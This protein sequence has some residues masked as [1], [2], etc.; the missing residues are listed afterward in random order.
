MSTGKKVT[1]TIFC[2]LFVWSVFGLSLRTPVIF[3]SGHLV[4]QDTVRTTLP[5]S[6]QVS[7]PTDSLSPEPRG[8]KYLELKDGRLHGR[9]DDLS[10]DWLGDSL[11]KFLVGNVVFYYNGVVMMCDSAV[12]YDSTF[13]VGYRNV[14]VNRGDTYIYGDKIDYSSVTKLAK[15]Y[16]PIVKTIDKDADATLYSYNMTFN[17]DRNIGYYTGGGAM[18]Q[19]D[20]RMESDRGY[21][22]V[23]SSEL[24]A[25]GGTQL[26]N[27]DYDFLSD[28]IRYNLDEEIAYFSTRSYI[29]RNDSDFL[30]AVR[31]SY[32]TRNDI[33]TFVEDSYI[34]TSAQEIWADSIYYEQEARNAVLVSNV[35]IVDTTQ[36]AMAFGDYA[37]YWGDTQ[38]ALL[39]RN[40]SLLSY[41]EADTM[42]IRSDSMFMY[43]FRRENPADTIA[44]TELTVADVT[45]GQILP[46][47]GTDSIDVDQPL[48]NIMDEIEGKPEPEA[49]RYPTAKELKEQRRREKQEIREANRLAKEEAR[50]RKRLA[51]EERKAERL[52]LKELI[53]SGEYH[54]DHEGHDH[55]DGD[56]HDDEDHIDIPGEDSTA[57]LEVP[58]LSGLPEEGAEH[59]NEQDSMLRIF[60]GYRNVKIYRNDFQA[61]CDSIV[62]F[63]VDS[64]LHMYIDPLMWND[65]NQIQATYVDIFTANQQIERAEFYGDPIMGQEVDTT[66]YSQVK[67]REMVAFFKEGDISQL[68]VNGNAQT[69]YYFEEEDELGRYPNGFTDVMSAEMAFRFDKGQ[70]DNIYWA[71][72]IVTELFS[73]DDIP[74]D[75]PRILPG[76]Q[77]F[78][79]RRP[80]KKDVFDRVVRPSQRMRYEGLQKPL[81]PTTEKIDAAKRTLLQTGGWFDRSDELTPDAQNLVQELLRGAGLL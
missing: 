34:M 45:E 3:G 40:P 52:A 53:L 11:V 8:P 73:M 56:E 48:A 23:D 54:H 41:S 28:S 43:S 30:T 74:E 19:G 31:G 24:V 81:F 1:Y 14:V 51:R 16:S 75:H 65:N 42:Y 35:Q 27:P 57:V 68:D 6:L 79:E 9:A 4:R 55:E 15:V 62:G 22:Y 37:R 25:V 7:M 69:Y 33:Y 58:V 44:A 60:K 36:K 10:Q 77:W 32:D 12:Q 70:L 78:G 59:E 13:F 80:V 21:Y 29:W 71:R 17:T 38:N 46:L 20:T 67:G 72:D 39:T 76:F 2:M 63:S 50:L 47:P 64:T 5:D 26:R 18:Y 49:P 61:V 66:H